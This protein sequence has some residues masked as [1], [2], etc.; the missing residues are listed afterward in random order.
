MVCP[1][2]HSI[3]IVCFTAIYGSKIWAAISREL[4]HLGD[5]QTITYTFVLKLELGVMFHPAK[6]S[7]HASVAYI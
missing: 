6:E 4:T 1:Q 7:R 5:L 3:S 2:Y